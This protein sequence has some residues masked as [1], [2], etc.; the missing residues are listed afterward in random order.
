MMSTKLV[1]CVCYR[2]WYVLESICYR[3]HWVA[4]LSCPQIPTVV[5]LPEK[6]NLRG[7]TGLGKD[8]VK[9]LFEF[10]TYEN[11][12]CGC[13]S[14]VYQWSLSWRFRFITHLRSRDK[15]EEFVQ[16]ERYTAGWKEERGA[17]LSPK[18]I[19][20]R[21]RMGRKG[22]ANKWDQESTVRKGERNPGKWWW[23]GRVA[24]ANREEFQRG[25]GD[26]SFHAAGKIRAESKPLPLVSGRE[27]RRWQTV[28]SNDW[29]A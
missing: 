26:Q 12:V 21:G 2:R 18:D 10:G 3:T 9:L 7:D 25:E 22:G 27:W 16:R 15:D 23:G 1:K 19:T 13:L 14:W 11:L 17:R 6:E 20:K 8:V 5:P 29:W 4:H 28:V 24:E